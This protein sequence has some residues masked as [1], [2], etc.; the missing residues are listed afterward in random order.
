M[1]HE[2]LT[3]EEA[4][5]QD[6]H[7]WLEHITSDQALEWVE[8][9]NAKSRERFATTDEFAAVERSIREVLD[10][11][12]KIPMVS[13]AGGF[14]YNFW[15]D[16]NHPRGL[17]RR[18]TEESYE[19]EQPQWDVLLDVDALCE[20]EDEQWVFH[21]ASLLRPD[22]DRALVSLSRG[23]TDADETREFD[24][25]TRS[26]IAPE[27]GGFFRPES[28]GG[29]RW[30]NRDEVFV[31]TDF[32]PDQDG[33]PT[34]T[35]SGY[36][37]IAKRLQ[38]GQRFE[39][40]AVV[41]AGDDE[42]MYISAWH[43]FTPGFERNFVSRSIAFYNSETY[44]L[45]DDGTLT[46]LEVPNS[47]EVSA[48][49][50][51]V[52]VELREDWVL[53]HATY[54]AGS[55][56]VT[57]FEKFLAGNRKFTVLFAPTDTTS[58]A[59]ASF[60]RDYLVLNVLADVKNKLSV[61]IPPTD[62]SQGQWREMPLAGLPELGT[63]S[64]GA[65]DSDESNDVWIVTTDYL[66]PTTLLRASLD[67][68]LATQETDN[69]P[70]L[71]PLKSMPSFFDPSRYAVSQNFAISDD[72]TRVPYFLIHRSDIVLDGTTPTLLYG[73]GGFE[74]SLT[75]NYSGALGRGW[76]ERGGAYAVAN[77]RGGGEYGP[78]W[79]QAALKEN[80][81]RAYQD[82]SSVAKDLIARGVTST[83]HLGV[84]GRSNG[85]LLTG[86]MLMQYPDLFGAVVIGVPLL[87]MKRYTHLLAGASWM[88]EYGDPDVPQEWDYISTFS[89]YHLF[90]A[91]RTYP[92][93]M[94]YTSTKD[95]RVH[96]GHARKLAA[97]MITAG[98]DVTYYE[99]TE[100]GH[101]G[102]S[103]NSQAAYVA[104]LSYQFLWENL[105]HEQ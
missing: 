92:P 40:A 96:P 66:T 8:V 36:P 4:V 19:S 3:Q 21:G 80:R 85:G 99:N 9:Q 82:F 102:S 88:A 57:D 83:P 24:L 38:R 74:I 105:S 55:L 77:I 60:T 64:V 86:N 41:Y 47:A 15:R 72:G 68:L 43:S 50:D 48:Y 90:D 81:H 46:L 23:G 31:Y 53:D 18:T 14:L 45:E 78:R 103:D 52:F 28:K 42:D 73:Y 84:E 87:D 6:P 91:G 44:L 29:L 22:Y 65:V 69:V 20:T 2:F 59:G 27:N 17:W 62:S 76:L 95:D 56:L 35:G 104:T 61:L 70:I 1:K 30:I 32:G 39:D 100:G 49:R 93:V 51:L 67:D 34:L 11:D 10:S 58:L 5:A 54:A 63:V 12:D 94:F 98:K 71:E 97:A 26:F 25:T 16:A 101:A 75:P 89:P 7:L 33:N 37:R 79:H 13:Y